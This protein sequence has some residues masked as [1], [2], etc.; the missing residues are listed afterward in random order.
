MV[1]CSSESHAKRSVR[2][3]GKHYHFQIQDLWPEDA[4]LYQVKVEDAEV[5]S[6]ELEASGARAP[7]EPGGQVWGGHGGATGWGAERDADRGAGTTHPKS[8][9]LS[10]SLF[11]PINVY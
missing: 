7:R 6:T 8:D 9:S 3:L 10:L 11:F 2:R 1:P 4:G 5:F